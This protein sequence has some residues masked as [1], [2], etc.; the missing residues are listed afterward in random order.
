MRKNKVISYL[1]LVV[2]RSFGVNR[3]SQANQETATN[4]KTIE[5]HFPL[6][7]KL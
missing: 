4:N 7:K 3:I 2:F 5:V 1:P 6:S